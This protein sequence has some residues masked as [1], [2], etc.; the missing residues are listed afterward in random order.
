MRR[1]SIFN[2]NTLQVSTSGW[3]QLVRI[4]IVAVMVVAAAE[5]TVRLDQSPKALA[6]EATRTGTIVDFMYTHKP[7]LDFLFIGSSQ[8]AYNISPADMIDN[9]QTRHGRQI[10]AFNHGIPGACI[11]D[12]NMLYEKLGKSYNVKNLVIVV[13]PNGGVAP[14]DSRLI[15]NYGVDDL[16]GQLPVAEKC[17]SNLHLFRYRRQYRDLRYQVYT[18]ADV[19]LAGDIK[20]RL[21]PYSL[22]WR[23]GEGRFDTE[24]DINALPQLMKRKP[25]QW[26]VADT[27]FQSLHETVI[28]AGKRNTH[29]ILLVPPHPPR[30]HTTMI[31]P[32]SEWDQ[33]IQSLNRI[34]RQTG[35]QVIDHHDL[36]QFTDS[37][38]FD[39]TH[40]KNK[41]AQRYSRFL[42][43]PIFMAAKDSQ[44]QDHSTVA[45]IPEQQ[46]QATIP[47]E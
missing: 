7:E 24:T 21:G 2:F 22:G 39:Y 26:L 4:L 19:N 13:T 30:F 37:D 20:R 45:K 33:F 16:T 25:R 27:V 32:E 35:C 3:L 12:V 40:L 36:P 10:T 17:L 8:C 28:L 43:Q 42:S 6:F 47:N 15:D 38:F 41:A 34:A 18:F 5:M 23:P 1:L 46:A 14:S 11:T 9:W 31:D 29:V 44:Q